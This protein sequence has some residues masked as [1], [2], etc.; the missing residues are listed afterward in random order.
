MV[1][2]E[3]RGKG[4]HLG[5]V[6]LTLVMLSLVPVSVGYAQ[7][8]NGNMQKKAEKLID[9]ADTASNKV[10]SLIELIYSNQTA[11]DTIKAAGLYDELE[12]NRS[13]FETW[14]VGNLTDAR[15]AL[16]L[17]SFAE[18]IAN[19]TQS[20]S[21]DREVIK[22]LNNI[23]ADSGVE[24][25]RLVYAQGLIEAMR[26]ALDTIERLRE[27]EELP[28]NVLELLNEAETYLNIEEA[29]IWL[30]QGRVNETAH[31]KTQANKLISEAHRY[32]K[33]LA[34]AQNTR[35]IQNYM[36][37]MEKFCNQAEEQVQGAGELQA[38]LQ[39]EVRNAI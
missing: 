28:E 18:A 22:A 26:R 20:L 11:I 8:L 37:I 34:K 35:R 1:G 39:N 5:A 17:G 38:R 16:S 24:R 23:L 36:R 13:L 29:R 6:L 9:L 10:E 25:G 7:N 15:H 30:S 12:A 21:I 2:S 3:R 32:L 19:A 4:K 14:G 33:G 27:I 31:N